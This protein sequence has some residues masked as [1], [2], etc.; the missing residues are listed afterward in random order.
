[1]AL[2]RLFLS[3]GP[4]RVDPFAY[5]STVVPL[6]HHEWG[7]GVLL[8]R[9]SALWGAAGLA[10]LRDFLVIG[11]A[12]GAVSTARRRGASVPVVVLSLPVATLLFWIGVTTV[13]AQMF[14]LFI[15]AWSL[16]LLTREREGSHWWWV[17]WLALWTAWV[18]LHAGFIVGGAALVL[19]AIEKRARGRPVGGLVAVAAAS[20][21]LVLLNPYGA[22]YY[23]YLGSA[24]TL[25]RP[26]ITEWR[27]VLNAWWPILGA[28]ALSLALAAYA[29]S[30]RGLRHSP[31]VLFLIACAA[32][33]ALHQRH[34]SLYAVAWL[35]TVPPLLEGTRLAEIA[36]RSAPRGRVALA[37]S[38]VAT[39][40]GVGA[41][42]HQR[43]LEPSLPAN[44][45]E[46]T[47]L[48]YPVGA[49]S[50][51]RDVG[52]GGRLLTP[53]EVGAFVTWKL[54]PAVRVSLDGRY[55]VAFAPELLERHLD[56]YEARPGWRA[57]L[58]DPEADAVLA[59]STAPVVASLAREPGW[60]RVYRDDSYQVFARD[61]RA[62]GLAVL[63]AR[64]RRFAGTFP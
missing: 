8:Y 7:T 32:E 63:D 11:T 22:A 50:Y 39:V 29:V 52:F 2:G 64:G 27:S 1:M 59:P 10:L 58:Q 48:T 21:L 18:N 33:A 35:C 12:L 26:L 51:L 25:D 36:L 24:W 53:F 47:R 41:Y 42:V 6:V 31:G 45:G 5:T 60:T 40:L 61:E 34:L 49:V 46:H 38:A 14:T 55:E 9:V 43:P 16:W 23:R 4:P 30:R 15:L 56:F 28:Y 13:R 57:L 20:G 44:A 62:G 17:P 54:Y 19:H 3:G 37:A